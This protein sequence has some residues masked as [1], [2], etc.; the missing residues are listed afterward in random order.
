[1]NT[2]RLLSLSA[3]AVLL[4]QCASSSTSTPASTAAAPAPAAS[5]GEAD[6]TLTPGM[7]QAQVLAKWG[8]PSSKKTTPQGEVWKYANQAWKRHVPYYGTFAHVEEHFVLFGAD[9]RLVKSGTEDYGNAFQ[10]PWR[11]AFGTN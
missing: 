6:T 3:A 7:T 5:A 11:R 8:E 2:L 9:G 4:S 10:E 1:M